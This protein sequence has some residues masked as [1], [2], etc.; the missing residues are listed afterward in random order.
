MDERLEIYETCIDYTLSWEQIMRRLGSR[1]PIY[2]FYSERVNPDVFQI[3][4]EGRK[5]VRIVIV[6]YSDLQTVFVRPAKI[7]ELLM[8]VGQHPAAA[9]AVL[10]K[11]QEEGKN[12][13]LIALGTPGLYW[14]QPMID[15]APRYYVSIQL[16]PYIWQS[17][18]PDGSNTVRTMDA[19]SL[20]ALEYQT[21]FGVKNG[22]KESRQFLAVLSDDV[23]CRFHRL[24][25]WRR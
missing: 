11:S 6:N 12:S 23:K 2:Q 7:E 20:E 17:K 3:V 21:N 1:F 22:W 4:G 10:Y 24:S 18:S 16:F 8:F 13:Q 9:E 19:Q 5:M 15:V 25:F 14:W